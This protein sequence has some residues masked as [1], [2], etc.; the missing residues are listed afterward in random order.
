MTSKTLARSAAD[1]R[2]AADSLL[3]VARATVP[4]PANDLTGLSVEASTVAATA[5]EEVADRV[6]ALLASS[7]AVCAEIVAETG[8]ADVLPVLLAGLE[9]GNALLVASQDTEVVFSTLGAEDASLAGTR[10]A[11]DEYEN[12]ILGNAA[13]EVALPEELTDKLEKLEMVGAE[14]LVAL[15][16]EAAMQTAL[17]NMVAGIASVAGPVV[18]D[19]FDWVKER[20]NF[21]RRAAVRVMEWVVAKFRGLVPENFRDKFDQALDKITEAISKGIEKGVGDILGKV[22][23]RRE[24]EDAWRVGLSDGKDLAAAKAALP[25]VISGHIKRVGYVST[26]RKAVSGA[27]AVVQKVLAIGTS[28]VQIALGALALALIAFVGWQVWDGFNDIEALVPA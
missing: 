23:G 19:A 13:A 26:G 18:K 14:E 3:D 27:A 11:L 7:D 6:D 9:V 17:G 22:L 21:V 20:V 16:R 4:L 2:T 5:E 15:G 28:Q 25:D 8:T 10:A 1:W 24:A 12:A